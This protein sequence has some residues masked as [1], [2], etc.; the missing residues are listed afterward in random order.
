VKVQIILAALLLV[1][2]SSASPAPKG[3]APVA[4]AQN[5]WTSGSG[6]AQQEYS[7]TKAAFDGLLQDEASA[8]TI[9]ALLHRGAARLHGSVP[10]AA[11]PGQAGLATFTLRN[12]GT[13]QVGFAVRD[14]EA[15]RAVYTRPQGQPADPAV[16]AA[17]QTVLCAS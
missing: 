15:T 14:G 5:D 6:D 8:V 12:G 16:A 1:A 10:F 11:C 3:W 7:Y 17:M 2:C 13:L 9:D 4:G